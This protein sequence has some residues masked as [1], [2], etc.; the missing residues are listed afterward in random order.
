MK[1]V[2]T[3]DIA[4]ALLILLVILGHVLQYAN[5]G[6]AILQ[7]ALVQN[8]ISSFHMPAFFLLSGYLF[9]E[10]KWKKASF[11]AFVRKRLYTLMIPYICFET[12]G[13]VY[14]ALVLHS[15]TIGEGFVKMI[16]LQCNVG[17]DWFL[18]AMFLAQI[19]FL[20]VIKTVSRNYLW[21][22][23]VPCMC[24]AWVFPTGALWR[25]LCRSVLALGFLLTGL[26][27]QK[28]VKPRENSLKRNAALLSFLLTSMLSLVIFKYASIDFYFCQIDHPL[29]FFLAGV[30][31]FMMVLSAVTWL[32]KNCFLSWLGKN[33]LVIM[34]T[35]QLVL[36]T[37]PASSSMVWVVGIFGSII[38]LECI[39]VYLSERYA[40]IL[41]GR[42]RE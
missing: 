22:F 38:M 2:G 24:A 31:G 21:F 4:K 27:L 6:Y 12:I 41:V 29:L 25:V 30:S 11:M 37:V 39:I 3:Y 28:H 26:V 14:K 20:L 16:T 33:T 18:P 8:W 5:P 23:I 34:G 35:H 17:A 13:L 15:Q 32:G 10:E 42:I 36:Y 9:N 7:Y 40:P 19:V 1:R